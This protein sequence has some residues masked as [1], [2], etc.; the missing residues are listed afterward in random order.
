[1]SLCAV[2]ADEL[3]A[4]GFRLA[5]ADVYVPG[6]ANISELFRRLSDQVEVLLVTAAEAAGLPTALLDEV[7]ARGRPLL[8]VIPDIR[9]IAEPPDLSLRLRKQLGLAE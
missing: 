8:L 5:G 3:T 7:L 1:M 9:G 2:I 6:P 4:G